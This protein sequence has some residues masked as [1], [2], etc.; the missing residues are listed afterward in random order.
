M[1]DACAEVNTKVIRGKRAKKP[2]EQNIPM[3]ISDMSFGALPRTCGYND[4]T[5]FNA[6]NLTTLNHEIHLLTGIN[7]AGIH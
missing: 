4:I 7:Y 3:F 6:N 2:L 5:S 1:V